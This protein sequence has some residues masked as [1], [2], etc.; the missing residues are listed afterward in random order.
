MELLLAVS[1]ISLLATASIV[2]LNPKSIYLRAL[3]T[4]RK[5]DLSRFKKALENYYND[6]TCYPPP[7]KVCYPGTDNPGLPSTRCYVCGSASGSPNLSPYLE[8]LLCDPNHP[9]KKYLYVID[10]VVCP[11]RY[12]IYTKFNMEDDADSI[13][14]GCAKSGC[15][16]N[17]GYDYGESSPNIPLDTT[18]VYYCLND[19][20][21]GNKTCDNCGSYET[22]N[23][24]LYPKGPCMQIFSDKLE[25]QALETAP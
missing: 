5:T 12:Q 1:I 22:C 3:D 18:S 11:K 16:P 9:T 7:E 19:D 20:G 8:E 24:R 21:Y 17:K 6:N 15:G 25:C 13:K 14:V 10:N 23:N 2:L 4:K